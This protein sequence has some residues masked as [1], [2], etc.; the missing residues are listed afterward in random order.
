MSTQFVLSAF[1]VMA[2]VVGYNTLNKAY[3]LNGKHVEFIDENT[4]K[5]RGRIS[6]HELF[7]M[8][9]LKLSP[10]GI[11]V[12]R[13]IYLGHGE[14]FDSFSVE[15]DDEHDQAFIVRVIRRNN[16]FYLVQAL[17]FEMGFLPK[18]NRHFQSVFASKSSSH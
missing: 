4:S 5:E 15:M 17:R 11:T 9:S 18:L 6:L 1:S 8:I 3:T 16:P 14:D 2:M 7:Q 13:I 12:S 10:R